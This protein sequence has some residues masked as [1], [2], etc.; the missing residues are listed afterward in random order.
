MPKAKITVLADNCVVRPLPLIGEHGF[1]AFVEREG[2]ALLFDTGQGFAL[3]QN[4][5]VLGIDLRRARAVALSHGHYDHTG[6]LAAFL[7]LTGPRPV[8]AHPGLFAPRSWK[9][10]DGEAL[11][12]AIPFDRAALEGRGA[13]FHLDEKWREL[14][15]GFH[16]TG[17]VPRLTSFE[18]GD[19]TLVSEPSGAPDPHPDDLS[20]VVEGEEGLAV[21]LG[22]AHAGVVNIL[23]HVQARFPGRPLHTV[24]GGTHLGF[25]SEAQL[26]ATIEELRGMGVRRL[27]ASHCTGLAAACRL[28]AALGD[29]F[30]FAG[31][32]TV[33]EV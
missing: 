3:L 21:L 2:E 12:I 27:G 28:H 20:L 23:R 11:S 33:A 29:R 26:A 4:A 5:R 15:P 19:A 16:L 18:G 7:S 17:E 9:R 14:L 8:H 13:V 24:M 31:A 25:A 10:P 32:G 1:A 22:C 30:F 6:G